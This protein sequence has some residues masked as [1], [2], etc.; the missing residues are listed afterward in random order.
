MAPFAK[1]HLGR[2]MSAAGGH[3]T[4]SRSQ[5]PGGSSRLSRERLAKNFAMLGIVGPA[6]FGRAQFESRDEFLVEVADD[7]LG[8][9]RYDSDDI[10]AIDARD[11]GPVNQ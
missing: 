2:G 4:D 10:A 3:R 1:E 7:Q 11:G 9:T 6:V 5:L 8:H